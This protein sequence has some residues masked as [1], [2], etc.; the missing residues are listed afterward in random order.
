[1]VTIMASWLHFS[2]KIDFSAKNGITQ[3]SAIFYDILFVCTTYYDTFRRE[4]KKNMNVLVIG[5]HS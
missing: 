3:Y 1:M 2:N 5:K 4:D